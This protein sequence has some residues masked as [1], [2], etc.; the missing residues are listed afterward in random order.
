MVL[1][2]HYHNAKTTVDT[3]VNEDGTQRKVYNL[4]FDYQGLIEGGAGYMRLMHFD[5]DN[6]KLLFVH[7]LLL[8]AV[9]N[10]K[11]MVIM[12]RNRQKIPML[13]MNFASKMQI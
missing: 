4:L 10:M 13:E 8:M 3:F 2:G 5:L 1:S 7:F 6:E 12:M 9:R 11:T